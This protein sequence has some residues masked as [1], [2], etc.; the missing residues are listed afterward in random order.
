[1][2]FKKLV[3]LILS[4]ILLTS[5]LTVFATQ[6]QA[7]TAEQSENF[8]GDDFGSVPPSILNNYYYMLFSQILDLY[9]SEHLYEF[10]EE[11]VKD[12]MIEKI[13]TENPSMFKYLI[14]QMLSTMDPYSS[15]HE[16]SSNFL[17]V[18]NAS[19]G[20]GI[21]IEDR[22]DGVYVKEVL[23][24]SQA[25]EAGIMKD[26]KII[27]V[28]GY[29]VDGLPEK[30]VM[31]ILK[32]PYI[33]LSSKNENGRYDDYNPPSEIVVLRG[34]DKL[35]FTLTRGTM[36]QNQIN[37]TLLDDG[38]TAYVAIASFLG[39]D[40]DK[41]FTELMYSLSENGTQNLTLDLR[42]NGG[43]SL[44]YALTMAEVFV[45]NGDILCYH[46]DKSLEKPE[47]IYSSTPKA[48]FKSVTIL[49]NENTASAAEL[50]TNILKT[51][52]VGKVVGTQ[53]YGK[54]IGQSVYTLR[55]GDYITITTYEILDKNLE[56]YNGYGIKPDIEIEN[57]EICYIL[58]PLES[59]NH[60]NYVDIKNDVYSDATLAL[61]QRLDVI[62]LLY[63]K[64]VDG[65]F[66]IKTG[67][68]LRIFQKLGQIEATGFVTFETVTKMTD[69]ING[70]KLD[71]YFEDSQYDVAMIIHR[72]FSQGKR[73]A[74]EK[75]KLAEENRAL[76]EQRADAYEEQLN[77]KNQ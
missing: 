73:L 3:A 10:T 41:K 25:L 11:Q 63:E 8:G 43:G 33:F 38:K 71:S 61:E 67:E 77:N 53:T 12:A 50:F 51:H 62:G 66:D 14:N 45:E 76:I 55:N 37:Y 17:N 9:V 7:G 15:Y 39:T 49:V 57:V 34:E 56:S 4:A 58:P 18:D 69:V 26:D 16:K 46:N 32:T 24:D 60:E 35:S 2:L 52:D 64:D 1:M 30:S 74:K 65:I 36:T 48:E 72:S 6:E 20:Y 13:L 59:F 21:M 54:S 68:A 70:F 19:T 23:D 29:Q 42:D 27:S 47:P 31:N 44:E 40:T 5:S 75:L 22:G 28:A